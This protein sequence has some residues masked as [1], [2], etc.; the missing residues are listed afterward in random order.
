MVWLSF[1]LDEFTQ[2]NLVRGQVRKQSDRRAIAG[3][4]VELGLSVARQRGADRCGHVATA[5]VRGGADRRRGAHAAPPE[6]DWS[7]IG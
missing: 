2:Q 3:E 7:P 1:P 4:Q 6:S 5:S